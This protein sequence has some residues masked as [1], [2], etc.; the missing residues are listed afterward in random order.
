M[1]I[2]RK[3]S[4]NLTSNKGNIFFWYY[5]KLAW[6]DL[7]VRFSKLSSQLSHSMLPYNAYVQYSSKHVSQQWLI[8]TS[9]RYCT[10]QCQSSIHF[11]FSSLS[12]S[13]KRKKRKKHA[14]LFKCS[15]AFSGLS[16]TLSVCFLSAEQT[17]HGVVLQSVSFA[18]CCIWKLMTGVR[19]NQHSKAAD[20]ET[21]RTAWKTL[22][23]CREP[24]VVIITVSMD[25][26]LWTSRFTTI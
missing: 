17:V 4:T 12:T 20:Q 3:H 21:K 10:A 7:F 9:S 18:A 11:L 13:A 2:T 23:F 5:F 1:L 25:L 15:I 24:P 8:Y 22:S 6:V 26:S 14:W 19:L 16:L